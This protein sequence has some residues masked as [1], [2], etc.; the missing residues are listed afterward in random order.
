[1]STG[2]PNVW[3]LR[4]VQPD[5]RGPAAGIPVTRLDDQGNA[6]GYWVSDA[7]GVVALPASGEARVRLRIGLRSEA[8]VELETAGFAAGP[9]ELPAPKDFPLA[10]ATRGE[11]A[12][13]ARVSGTSNA[14][15]EQPGQVLHFARLLMLAPPPG[16]GE[17]P[18]LAPPPPPP[19]NEAVV[20]ISE[21]AATADFFD[22]GDR[23]PTTLRYGALVEIE[24]HWQPIGYA[25][26]ELLYTATLTPGDET[27][28]VVL[29]GR[30]G[31]GDEM[32]RDRP[33]QTLARQIGSATLA[34]LVASGDGAAPLEP[35]TLIADAAGAADALGRG[36]TDTVH[37]LNERAGR[38]AEGLR[39]APLRVIETRGD[40]PATTAVRVLR[41]PRDDRLLLYH[42]YEPL[43]R[44]RVSA[45]AARLRPTV[46]IPFRLPNLA[47]RGMVRQ[48]GS[49]IR[50][51][52]LDRT[53]LPELDGLLG[54]DSREASEWERA[55]A[56]PPISELRVIV[57]PKPG[58]PAPELGQLWCYL[59]AD[60]ARYTV[61]FFPIGTVRGPLKSAAAAAPA[62]HWIGAIRL[63]DFHQR[64]LRYP[65]ELALENGSPATLVFK[66]LHLEGR[67]GDSWR[68]LLSVE[69][70]VFPAQS[71]VQLASLAALVGA[72]GMG[73]GLASR[74][75]RL[76]G[77]VAAH[78]PYYAAAIIAGGDPG[79]RYLALSKVRD[80]QNRPLADLIENTVAGVVG[81]YLAFPLLTPG[82][83]PSE[84]RGALAQLAARPGRVP[85]E[86]VV[87]FP[88][89]GV[90]L[91]A[92]AGP[93]IEGLAEADDPSE[94]RRG[95]TERLRGGGSVGRR[96]TQA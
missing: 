67:L 10:L 83:A 95:G 56:S 92:Q 93:V 27:R 58:A 18:A 91:G 61:H 86:V 96:I 71:Q 5:G 55:G 90:W 66:A 70:I 35:L 25:S 69:G 38:V 74:E 41:N 23:Y 37:Y 26:G 30:W 45:R 44:Y 1:M 46:L 15:A 87:T 8:P 34:D 79:V 94:E 3:I 73:G 72:S 60:D 52:L 31:D 40:V 62:N 85:D 24:Q 16:D 42:F 17:R 84:L 36:A 6:A 13:V 89:P 43:Q 4:I 64:P 32:P 14:L 68:R 53:L 59:R 54:L 11:R 39:R 9:L 33:L 76:L 80:A 88:L 51:A 82:Y 78:L 65:G 77:H 81:N 2:P 21:P 50:R 48:F 22:L 57:E 20:S 7:D 28:I 49:L 75:S 19:A 47:V 29:D 12:P 63:A